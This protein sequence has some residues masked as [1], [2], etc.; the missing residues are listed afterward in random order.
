MDEVLVRAVTVSR[1]FHTGVA[2]R[3]ALHEASCSVYAGDRIAL[4]GP[5][6]SGKSTLLHLLGGLDTPTRGEVSW[7]ALG[8]RNDLR[9][10][11]ITDVFQGP[12]LLTPLTVIENARLPLLLLGTVEHEADDR[13]MEFLR[14]FDV[15]H[16]R[17]KLPEEISGGQAQRVSIARALT[18]RPRL[19]LADEPTGQLDSKTARDVLEM[20]LTVVTQTGAAMIIST[21]D[22]LVAERLEI[23]WRMRDGHLDAGNRS[24]N[25]QVVEQAEPR[26][27]V[28][29]SSR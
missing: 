1:R 19:V 18:V 10:A 14:L 21:H 5:S 17:D 9:P 11:L 15:A 22:P 23:V 24:L 12:S 20:L 26:S 13:A 4:T 6:G 29:E 25:A 27:V 3:D 8:S 7:P 2:G 28:L 16:L